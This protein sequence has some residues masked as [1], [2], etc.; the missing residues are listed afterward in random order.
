M[1]LEFDTCA[2]D[3]IKPNRLQGIIIV[4]NQIII[5]TYFKYVIGKIQTADLI[6]LKALEI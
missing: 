5:S 6:N 3:K 4:T 2:I 1:V